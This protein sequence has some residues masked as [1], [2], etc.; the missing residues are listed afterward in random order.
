MNI[1]VNGINY[2]I[3]IAG[4]GEPVLLLHG[5][6]GGASTWE[7]L[8]QQLKSKYQFIMIDIIG[9]GQTTCSTD[10]NR[11]EMSSVVNDLQDILK[12]LRI[13]KTHILGYSMGGRLALSFA[14]SYPNRLLSLMIESAT[15]GLKTEEERVQRQRADRKLAEMISEKGIEQFVDYW[16]N[17]PLF[18][19]QKRLAPVVREGIRKQ[20]LN[21]QVLGLSNS[22][23]GM[24]TGSQQSLWTQLD[25]IL[26]DCLLVVGENDQK[27]CLIADEMEI[28]LKHATKVIVENTG[29]AVHVENPE[30]FGTIIEEFLS[31]CSKS[32]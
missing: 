22:L 14:T 25:R 20:R 27:F 5:F 16:E 18:A 7:T 11:Y 8:V 30:K 3:E 4:N 23:L 21:N 29:H 6:T 26:C 1:D 15:P 13:E 10:V 2:H 31:A 19:T 32:H 9:H 12:Q 24:G 17:I 28:K